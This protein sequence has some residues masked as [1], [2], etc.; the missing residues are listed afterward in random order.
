M[1]K[2]QL[3]YVNERIAAACSRSGRNPGDVTIVAVTKTLPPEVINEAIDAG[4]TRIGENRVQEYL[5]KKPS[6]LPHTF[7]MIGALQR[8]KVRHIIDSVSLI[9]SV[10]SLD[11]VEEIE[12]RAAAAGRKIEVLLEVNTSG[13]ASKH[14]VAPIEVQ[15]LANDIVNLPHV[16]LRG[17]MTVAEFAG[18]PEDV[19]PSFRMLRAMRGELQKKYPS[20]RITE[21][22]MGMTNDYVVAIEEGAT[23]VRLGT[24]LFGMRNYQ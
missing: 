5:D 15:S 10:D 20:E 2:D 14:G 4:L 23:L 13:E 6:L 3:Q 22:S 16:S 9:H 11:L 24:A 19:R 7:H 21:L 8:N 1:V 12:K 18:N 17:L